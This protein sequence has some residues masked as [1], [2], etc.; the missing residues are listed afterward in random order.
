M[1]TGLVIWIIGMQLTWGMLEYQE[2][3]DDSLPLLYT[4]VSLAV[5]PIMLGNIIVGIINDFKKEDNESK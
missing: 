1:I 2:D 4:M 3:M 5:W